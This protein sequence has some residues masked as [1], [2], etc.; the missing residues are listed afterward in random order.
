MHT[1]IVE[2]LTS[3]RTPEGRQMSLQVEHGSLHHGAQHGG[4]AAQQ[5]R[6][7]S[8]S[9]HSCLGV[10]QEDV[11]GVA[12]CNPCAVLIWFM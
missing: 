3:K 10:C 11:D 12:R 8:V 9:A 1:E 5:E 4:S 7:L 6:L 2:V